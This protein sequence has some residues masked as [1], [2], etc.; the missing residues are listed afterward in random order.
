MKTIAFALTLILFTSC[1]IVQETKFEPNGSGNYSLGF[2]FSEMMKMGNNVEKDSNTKQ[3]D[4]LINFSEFLELKKDS[5]SKLS[6]EKQD[7]IK[8]LERFSLHL[9]IDSIS[10]K[11]VMKID[12]QF[13]DVSELKLFGEKLQDQKIKELKLFSDKTKKN[14]KGKGNGIPDFN[15]YY[16]LNFSKSS[17]SVKLNSL[18]VSETSKNKDTTLTKDNPM[19]NMIRFKSRYIFPYK[20][21]S[22]ANENVRILPNFK[23]I[24]IT[25]NLFEINNNPKYFDVTVEFEDE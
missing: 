15:K 7:K 21:K 23:G 2:D 17:F 22:V 24:E 5:I 14:K 11:S 16:D 3:L 13:D 4:T 8:Q 20:I 1:E 10:K 18:G 25:G 9:K 19:A 6:K 12:Y